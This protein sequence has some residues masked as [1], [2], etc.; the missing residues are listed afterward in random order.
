M[1]AAKDLEIRNTRNE[2]R[3]L[4]AINGTSAES[5]SIT[6]KQKMILDDYALF[7]QELARKQ[8]DVADLETQLA[9]QQDLLKK[10]D[11][12]DMP[13]EEVDLL[14]INDPVT[15]ELAM[16]LA[17]KKQEEML[18][19]QAAS[20]N[21]QNRY[22]ERY[23]R[24]LKMLQDEYD[25]K[26]DDAKKKVRERRHLAVEMDLIKFRTSFNI[27]RQQCDVLMKQVDK[28]KE[29][30]AKFGSSTVDIEMA[31]SNV[32]QLELVY[33]NLDNERE[34]VKVEFELCSAHRA[35]GTGGRS[36]AAVEPAPAGW[37][38]R[39]WRC[40]R[41]SVAR[42]SWWSFGTHAPVASTRPTTSPRDFGC[43]SSARCR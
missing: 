35:L 23:M 13:T 14:L 24:D 17:V 34:K 39:S 16:Q 6:Q 19:G 15:R 22:R 36:L 32:K 7:R 10:V 40:W 27:K 25:K 5:E 18:S 31:K 37:R 43:R 3:S 21:S 11:S 8:F 42:R 38:C 12:G 20:S 28:L 33:Q 30:A 1:C 2:L 41:P 29:E 4:A 9:A 26:V